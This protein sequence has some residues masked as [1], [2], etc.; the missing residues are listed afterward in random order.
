MKALL[1]YRVFIDKPIPALACLG[2]P[3]LA[4][5]RKGSYGYLFASSAVFDVQGRT[6]AAMTGC[7]RAASRTNP[8]PYSGIL[9]RY[10]G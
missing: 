4:L 10:T 8:A 7:Q 5:H 2:T 1:K 9:M 6:N 3:E